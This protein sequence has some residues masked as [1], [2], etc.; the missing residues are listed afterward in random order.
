[1]VE[2]IDLVRG[3]GVRKYALRVTRAGT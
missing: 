2:V 3:A 1:V